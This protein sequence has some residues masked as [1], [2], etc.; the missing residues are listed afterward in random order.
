[1]L[2]VSGLLL[3]EFMKLRTLLS[4]TTVVMLTIALLCS[5][6]ANKVSADG[7]NT[8]AL[9]PSTLN[10]ISVEN[11]SQVAQLSTLGRG[12][13]R[14]IAWAPDGKNLALAGSL[15]IWMHQVNSPA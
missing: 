8:T 4:S 13:I 3:E 12:W 11:A 7:P 5:G 10:V 2:L 1:M 14:S 15:G 6:N 9:L